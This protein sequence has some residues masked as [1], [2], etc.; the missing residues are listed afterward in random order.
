MEHTDIHTDKCIHTYRQTDRQTDMQI[1]TY[2]CIHTYILT[3]IHVHTYMYIHT[4]TYIHVHTYMDIQ[5]W[6]TR[7]QVDR[8]FAPKVPSQPSIFDLRSIPVNFFYLRLKMFNW[9]SPISPEGRIPCTCS[10]IW[11]M[12]DSERLFKVRT[13]MDIQAWTTRM[14]VD[15]RFAPKVPSQP[16]IFDLRSIP[17]KNF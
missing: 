15:R 9:S 2:K 8:R 11:Y 12:L 6:T 16:S 3:H 5:A 13:Y 4:S 10:C 17:V 7:M 14:Q 1:S